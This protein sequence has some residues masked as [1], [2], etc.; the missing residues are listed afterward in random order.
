M[1]THDL[2]GWKLEKHEYWSDW[3]DIND[4]FSGHTHFLKIDIKYVDSKILI[5]IISRNDD[6][7]KQIID[8]TM[9]TP[10]EIVDGFSNYYEEIRKEEAWREHQENYPDDDWEQ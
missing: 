9:L 7:I 6:S 4:D 1:F 10:Q 8:I 2:A 5:Y 3:E